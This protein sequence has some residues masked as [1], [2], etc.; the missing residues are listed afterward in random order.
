MQSWP[1]TFLMTFQLEGKIQAAPC[2]HLWTS[3]SSN[4]SP[5]AHHTTHTHIH[6]HTHFVKDKIIL[7]MRVPTFKFQKES[8]TQLQPKLKWWRVKVTCGAW[9]VGKSY[10]YPKSPERFGN[11]PNILV[12]RGISNWGYVSRTGLE[13]T[14]LPQ[15]RILNGVIDPKGP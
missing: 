4:L 3:L 6:T 8:A 12:H 10:S 5:L 11:S 1:Y 13:R 7:P 9:R 14:W 15:F 2:S